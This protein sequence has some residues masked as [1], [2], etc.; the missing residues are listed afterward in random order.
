M[1]STPGASTRSCVEAKFVR[2]KNAA[3][4]GLALLAASL[5][6]A[7]ATEDTDTPGAGRWEMNVGLGAV[8]SAAGWEMALPDTDFNYGW[9]ERIQLMLA[10]PRV[11]LHETAQESKSGMGAATAGLKWRLFEQEGGPFAL[12]AFPKYSWS[13][14]SDSV[15]RGLSPAGRSLLLPL[16]AGFKSGGTGLFIELGRNF[17]ED[18]PSESAAGVK[19][20]NACLP[21][22]ECRLE[23]QHIRVP[24][25]GSQTQ[26][27]AGAKWS[28]KDDLILQASVGRAIGADYPEKRQLVLY[29]GLQFLR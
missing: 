28:L 24:R 27:G 14:S 19:L 8:R 4:F 10:I 25:Q 7:Q 22:V 11:V 20:L 16:I 29:L 1:Y 18:A 23:L 2:R 5:A 3:R 13:P 17:I 12:A 21:R 9:G 26:A 6:P 15:E